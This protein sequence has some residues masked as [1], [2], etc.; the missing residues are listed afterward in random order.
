MIHKNKN[1]RNPWFSRDFINE[2]GKTKIYIYYIIITRKRGGEG[3]CHHPVLFCKNCKNCKGGS[4]VVSLHQVG[5]GLEVR[6]DQLHDDLKI[7]VAHLLLIPVERAVNALARSGR[8]QGVDQMAE[9]GIGD[10]I[11]HEAVL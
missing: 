6:S 3:S 9:V 10:V 7:R 8:Q 2:Y 5:Y 1:K 11:P 4:T